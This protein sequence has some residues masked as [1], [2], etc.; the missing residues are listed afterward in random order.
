MNASELGN[1]LVDS[2]R[3]R[4]ESDQGILARV[5]RLHRYLSGTDGPALRTNFR[6]LG[7]VICDVGVVSR[8]GPIVGRG[9]PEADWT[10][11]LRMLVDEILVRSKGFGFRIA[12]L[13][14][15]VGIVLEGEIGG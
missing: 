5:T 8:P 9:M 12:I 15:L 7:R 13:P 1:Y 3:G 4:H 2:Q 6:L 11:H 10:L 14:I